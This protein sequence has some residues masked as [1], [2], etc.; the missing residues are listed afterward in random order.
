MLNLWHNQLGT[1][2]AL[3][4]AENLSPPLTSLNLENN[5]HFLTGTLIGDEGAVVIAGRLPGLASLNLV[6]NGVGDMGAVSVASHLTNL[7]KLDLGRTGISPEGL[8]VL[9]E[10]LPNLTSLSLD[11]IHVDNEGGGNCRAPPQLDRPQPQL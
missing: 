11:C 4:I 8:A 10:G 3:A 5:V 7:T 9:T 6:G 1:A 2:G